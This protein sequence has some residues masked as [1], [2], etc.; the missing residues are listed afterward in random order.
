MLHSEASTCNMQ[1]SQFY[2]EY[3]IGHSSIDLIAS[4][5]KT[6]IKYCYNSDLI[7]K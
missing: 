7:W 1:Q 6:E 3:V 2:I 4:P 5:F